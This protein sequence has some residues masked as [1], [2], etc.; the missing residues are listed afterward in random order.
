MENPWAH[1]RDCLTFDWAHYHYVRLQ[2]SKSDILEGLGLWSATIIKHESMHNCTAEDVLWHSADALHKTIDM[3]QAGDAP[4]K[5]Y[6]FSYMGP[7]PSTPLAWMKETYEL[8]THNALLLLEQQIATTNFLG[9]AEYVPY[10][11]FDAKGDH[12]FSNLTSGDWASH[13]AVCL[14][15]YHTVNR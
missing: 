9:Q 1:F 5:A 7:K 15:F 6:K 14:M 2:S 10:Q 11:E 12:V 3:I 4:W 8:N 13:E